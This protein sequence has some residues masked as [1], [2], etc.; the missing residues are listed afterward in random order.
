[1]MSGVLLISAA[2]GYW[3][4]ERAHREKGGLKTVGQ[5]LGAIIIIVSLTGVLCAVYS[6]VKN[7]GWCPSWPGKMGACPIMGAPGAPPS[8]KR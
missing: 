4:L 1:M 6:I 7:R 3:V 2:A 5:W 8:A